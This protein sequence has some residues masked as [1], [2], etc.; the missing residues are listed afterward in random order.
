MS[1]LLNLSFE[2]VGYR[3]E[4]GFQL[5]KMEDIF[6]QSP[7]KYKN[8]FVPH[9]IDFFAVLLVTEGKMTHEVEFVKYDMSS[10]DYLFISKGQIHNF[11]HSQTYK[12]YGLIFT[13]EFMLR[14]ISLSAFLKIKFFYKYRTN[15]YAFKDFGDQEILIK[16]LKREFSLDTGEIKADVIAAILTVFLLKAQAHTV[17]NL[18]HTRKDYELFL[19]FQELVAE[20]Y[21]LTRSANE[22]AVLLNMTFRQL[23]NLCHNFTGKSAKEYINDYI[24]LEAKRWL[25][26][27]GLPIKR[28]AYECGFS[29]AT[30][31]LK[32]F[33]KHTGLTPSKFRSV[34]R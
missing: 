5:V 10:G 12:G 19:Q 28:I 33:K 6:T 26:T 18:S 16:A 29:E 31:F 27:T 17:E 30:N 15:P 11:D 8:P 7:S 4:F 3:K 25:V 14:H 34:E 22:Y 24:I 1:E 2:S 21:A 23:K 32:F 13:E 9:R 20:K